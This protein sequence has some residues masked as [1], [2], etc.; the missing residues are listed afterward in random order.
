MKR[1]NIVLGRI[2]AILLAICAALAV[3]FFIP[4]ANI[5]SSISEVR[6]RPET[7]MFTGSQVPSLLNP[8]ISVRITLDTNTTIEFYIINISPNIL[9][10]EIGYNNLTK[11]DEFK[12]NNTD[13]ILLNKEINE[14]SITLEYTPS[15]LVN[16]S[17]II[18]NRSPYTASISC[19]IELFT[20]IA[21]KVRI[22]LTITYLAPVG[23]ALTGQWILIEMKSKKEKAT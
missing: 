4:S 7:F 11:F 5:R 6:V 10:E 8:Q 17:F 16:A 23:A 3:L 9:W 19:K 1:I 2:G 22:I 14:G 20:S 18:V 15:G 13:K 12:R 21:P